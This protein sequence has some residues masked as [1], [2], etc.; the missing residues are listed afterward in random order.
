MGF[1]ANF[2]THPLIILGRT[3]SC[4]WAS[5]SQWQMVP[6][7]PE[8]QQLGSSGE[9]LMKRRITYK[10]E[11]LPCASGLWQLRKFPELGTV[12]KD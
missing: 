2:A 9:S 3:S 1:S 10:K 11:T 4:L 6:H 12:F 7:D 5:V 8:S